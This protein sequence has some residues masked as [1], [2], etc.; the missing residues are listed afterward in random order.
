MS[1]AVENARLEFATYAAMDAGD[2]PGSTM[3]ATQ[4]LLARWQ[5]RQ[6][7]PANAQLL[8]LG[9]A[10][11]TGE[12]AHAILKAAQGIRGQDDREHHVECVADAIADV[13]IYL[14]Q[15]ATL[16][17]L[18]FGELYVATAMRVIQR[19]WRKDSAAG[20]ER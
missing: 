19:D 3:S 12:L 16:Y 11:E 18:D 5:S 4:V 6:F 8:A 13:A 17:R 9:V 14:T 20:G 15:L 7:G 1:A 10:E 2:L